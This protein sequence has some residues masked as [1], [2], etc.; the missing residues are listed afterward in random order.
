MSALNR[1][2][3]RKSTLEKFNDEMSL[4]DRPIDGDVE[5]VDEAPPKS[6]MRG[7]ALFAGIALGLG[8]GGGVVLSR[9]HAA[10]PPRA[11]AS[12]P[13]AAVIAAAPPAPA[14]VVETAPVLAAQVPAAAA[15]PA[16]EPAADEESATD[17]DVTAAP[18]PTPGA[19]GKVKAKAGHAKHARA[20]SGKSSHH[21][22]RTVAAKHARH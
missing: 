14:P 18:A 21:G 20:V 4:L 3:V 2:R 6:R 10:A 8:L 5:Y 17:D 9:R 13:A 12:Q 1:P 11:E 7:V 16:P 22:K 15:A 19:W